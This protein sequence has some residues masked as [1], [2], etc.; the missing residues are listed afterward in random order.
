M[1]SASVCSQPNLPPT[2]VGPSR[3]WIRPE[4]FRSSQMNTSAPTATTLSR[5]KAWTSAAIT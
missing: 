4:T 2:R 5:K 3:S 1:P